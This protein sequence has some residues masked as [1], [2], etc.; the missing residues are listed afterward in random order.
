MS[1]E[2]WPALPYE[3]W[4]DT[5]AT[6]HMW[7]QI[8]GK[9]ALVLAPPLNHCW[10]I[11]LHVTSRGL[12]TR[13]LPHSGRFFTLEFDF[14]SHR[15]FIRT[16]DG[17]ERAM[18]LEARSV[19]DFY[20][21][22][23]ATLDGMALS[24][25]IWSMPVEIPAPIRFEDDSVHASYDP[26]FAQ[27]FWRVVAQM[28]ELFT[29]ARCGFVGKCSP[30]NFFWGS[31][32]LALTR[33]SGRIAP[34]PS[35]PAFVRDAYSHE[36]ISHGFWPGSGA[37]LEP[38]LYAYAVPDPVGFKDAKVS[39]DAAFFHTELGEFILPYE[40]VRAAKS[41]EAAIRAFVDSTYEQGANLAQWDRAALERRAPL[42]G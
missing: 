5:Y 10:A 28:D 23:M 1:E 29:E 38:A 40:A 27:R 18:R 3:A 9:V 16:S 35:G 4:K 30:T 24:V 42:V 26:V 7:T 8:V 32:D 41:P 19:A 31:F 37:L 11:A 36:V 34:R 33:F 39:P 2:R 15:L 13:P 6:L 21:E 14:I 25:K 20:R 22:L 17:V 12:A